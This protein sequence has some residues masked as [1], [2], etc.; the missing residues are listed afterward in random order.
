MASKVLITG[1]SGFIAGHLARTLAQIG[2]PVVGVGRTPPRETIPNLTFAPL[3]IRDF[4]ALRVLITR[5]SPTTIYHLAAESVLQGTANGPRA[6]LETNVGGTANVL[7]AAREAQTPAIVV[8]SSDKQ[9]GAL[10]VPPYDDS[11]TT[12]FLNGGS[13]ELSKAQQDQTARL[14]AGMFDVPA[15]RVARLANIYGPG[16]TQWTRLVPN[17]IRRTVRNEAPVVRAGAGAALREYVFVEDAVRALRAL[18]D[19]ALSRRNGPLRRTQGRL[20]AVAFNIGSGQNF[21]A[22]PVIETIQRIMR[23]E[24]GVMGRPAEIVPADSGVFEP[25][26][27]FNDFS[28]LRALLPDYAPRS[29]EEGL[30]ATIPWYLEHL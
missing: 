4:D 20:A 26:S 24:F 3:D 1:I 15:V 2:I 23:D 8:A 12:A 29:L 5:E 11:D 6:L 7:E 25:G 18:A 27:Q 21:A 30:R 14:Y 22:A 16:D 28:K 9:Y 17:T 13:Y 10:A 19:D